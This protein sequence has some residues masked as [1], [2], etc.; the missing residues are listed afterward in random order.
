MSA[1][2]RTSRR[3]FR[4]GALVLLG[5]VFTIDF[6]RLSWSCR[7]QPGSSVTSIPTPTPSIYIASIFWNSAAILHSNWNDAVLDLAEKLGAEKIYVSIY[8]SGSWD[9]S[10]QVLRQLESS[11]V[12]RGIRHRII[13]DETTHQDDITRP[14]AAKGWVKTPRGKTEL[15]R[16]SYLSKLRNKTLD[17]LT[18]L[19]ANGTTFEKV[20]FLND[21]AF[22]V[23]V[24][25]LENC[26]P[27][28]AESGT[29]I[30]DVW[31]LLATNNGQYA[32]VCSL[33]FLKPPNFYDTFA[34][35]DIEGHERLMMT[36]PY[37][38][39]RASR[40]AMVSY[41]PVPVQSCWNGMGKSCQPSRM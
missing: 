15:R 38:R 5:I 26:Y 3:R 27:R 8:E 23:V 18:E 28:D 19:A 12:T 33:D 30:Q 1:F 20:L 17:P 37:V 11:L 25:F 36:Y 6:I 13:L 9:E 22:T 4:R 14:P 34:L 39:A 29:W 21:V 16:I 31:T 35:R 32:A 7:H 24:P 41:R 10:K 40:S 2:R